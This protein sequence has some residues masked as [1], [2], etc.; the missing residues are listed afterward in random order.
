MNRALHWAM[1]GAAAAVLVAAGL[2]AGVRT[3]NG[4]HAAVDEPQYLLT[5]LSLW[6]DRSLDI[7]DEL[8]QERWR[9]FHDTDI[10]VQTEVLDGGR[11]VSPHDPLL[12]LLL[13]VPMGLG[14]WL[15]AKLALAALAAAIAALT[16]WVAVRRFDVTPWVAGT[17]TSVA[18]AAPP[19]AVYG[20][21]VYPELPAAGAVVLAVAAATGRLG[22]GGLLTVAAATVALPWLSVKYVPVAVVIA[23]LVLWRLV[24]SHRRRAAGALGAGLGVAGLAYLGLHQLWWG[25]WTVYASGDHFTETGE[26][27]VMGV[28]PDLAG[29]SLRLVALL[30]DRGY[31]IAAWAPIWVLG[32]V[33]VAA[34]LRRRPAGVSL[35]LLPVAAGWAVATWAAFTMHGFWWP[36]RQLVVVLPLLLIAI[37]W[38]TDRVA[39]PLGRAIAA[40]LGG[41]S[42]LAMVTLLV[43]GLS[44]DLTWVTGFEDVRN[45]VY[46]WSRLVL[47]DYR[48]PGTGMWVL[49]GLWI[50]ALS[51]LAVCG[52]R[53]AASRTPKFPAPDP[54]VPT[55]EL[56]S[57]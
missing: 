54:R 2:A 55:A 22:R 43:G 16:V 25:G 34:M 14:G 35:L 24:R 29:R 39:G 11:Q 17:G 18:F 32:V 31:G 45:P 49:H 50:A 8:Q 52:W 38:W 42:V 3:T 28:S 44:G 48:H 53:Q 46:S 12:P 30:V 23:G 20:S 7:S 41:V 13:A 33:A 37:L 10:P 5:A 40:V 21:Q 47:P 36:G 56:T 26:L 51:L 19:L 9:A 27:S 57:V 1:L 15:A 4:G 6:E